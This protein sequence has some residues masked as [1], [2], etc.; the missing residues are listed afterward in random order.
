[1]SREKDRLRVSLAGPEDDEALRTLSAGSPMPGR[2]RVCY[3]R[4]PSF[5]GALPVHGFESQVVIGTAQRD[6]RVVGMGIRSLKR[7]FVNGE[8]TVI[9][10]LSGLRLE[11]GYRDARA[12][13]R[14]F[15]LFEEL[16]GDERAQ[17][18][19]TTILQSNEAASRLLTS[20]RLGLPAYR[21]HGRYCCAALSAKPGARSTARGGA[22]GVRIRFATAADLS[23]I[24]GFWE[25]V[26]PS[27]QFFP[28]YDEGDLARG[29]G[30]LLGLPVTEVALA[31]DG[32]RI[33]GTAAAWDQSGFRQSVVASY[34]GSLRL[35]RPLYNLWAAAAGHPRLPRP[36]RPLRHRVLS[37]VAVEDDT[38]GILDALIDH[39]QARRLERGGFLVAGMHERDPLLP[40]VAGRAAI[41]YDARLYVVHWSGDSATFDALD[42]R[43]PCVELGS[44]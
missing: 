24:L 20:G 16:H 40:A 21:D 13:S 34:S 42:G 30:S 2:I 44:L 10:Y 12:F 15:R 6:G 31:L 17:L 7:A 33:V 36:G 18:Y 4:D 28:R 23:S 27:R 8:P 22:A 9:G 1:M 41:R 26:G 25:R 43:V 38:P 3:A 19:I 35:A 29:T 5:F 14:G 11:A 32:G 37:L 39:L